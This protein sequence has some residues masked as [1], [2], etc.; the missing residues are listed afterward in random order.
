MEVAM[1]FNA[2]TARRL[3]SDSELLL[4]EQSR[5]FELQRLNEKQLKR[6]MTRARSLREKAAKKKRDPEA[7]SRAAL[8]QFM[9]RLHER[10]DE[11]EPLPAPEHD[12]PEYARIGPPAE[13][14][15][16]RL[17][18]QEVALA[19]TERIHGMVSSLDRRTQVRH[20]K[21]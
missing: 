1:T 5:Q 15:K 21:K 4:Y 9:T 19:G 16:A 3:C 20:D 14:A 12:G 13:D 11:H 18:A 10:Q 2:R 17:H 8:V 7:A 6:N